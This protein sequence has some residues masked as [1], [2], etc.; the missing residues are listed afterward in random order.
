[1]KRFINLKK[2]WLVAFF[3][4]AVVFFAIVHL[5]VS[6]VW[7]ENSPTNKETTGKTDDKQNVDKNV[8]DK[9]AIVPYEAEFVKVTEKCTKCHAKQ[10]SSTDNLKKIKWIV[11]GKPEASPIYKVIGKNKKP[12]GTYHNLTGSEKATVN[13]YIN[14]LGGRPGHSTGKEEPKP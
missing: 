1:M 10:F 6:N 8:T 9:I 14:K 2:M 12:N 3:V 4:I 7:A 11:P 5:A 13:D